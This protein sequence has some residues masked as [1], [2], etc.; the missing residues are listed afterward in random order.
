NVE[1]GLATYCLTDR[2]PLKLYKEDIPQGLLHEY[3]FASCN[4]PIFTPRPINGK[5]Y[6]DGSIF[7]KLPVEMAAEK[8]C[9]VIIAVRLRPEIYNFSNFENVEIIDIAPD[10]YLSSTLEA[11]PERIIWMII[12]GY[13]DAKRI[14][15]KKTHLLF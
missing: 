12:K 4:L 8:G 14:L 10:E 9:N 1:F 2:K 7:M 13:E 6:L 5:Y 11:S 3:V 15:N